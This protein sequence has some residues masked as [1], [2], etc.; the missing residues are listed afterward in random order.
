M[1]VDEAG[2][3]WTQGTSLLAQWLRFHAPSAGG[4]KFDPWS[5]NRIPHTTTKSSH[6][7]AEDPTT[8]EDLLHSTGNSAQCHVAAWM[9]HWRQSLR[10]D[11]FLS[12]PS[13][14]KI[15]YLLGKGFAH[16]GFNVP[17]RRKATTTQ[18]R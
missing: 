6:A 4:A 16:G 8:S 11:S 13:K 10:S 9:V 14:E 3:S 12:P 5:V 7:A 1:R 2:R 15:I 18:G 17:G